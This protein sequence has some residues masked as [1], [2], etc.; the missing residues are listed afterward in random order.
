MGQ[1]PSTLG[2]RSNY[3]P[4]INLNIGF[5]AQADCLR[6]FNGKLDGLLMAEKWSFMHMR[7]IMAMP[8]SSFVPLS[9]KSELRPEMWK[10]V[11][12]IHVEILGIMYAI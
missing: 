6:Q 11:Q 9:S 2:M 4:K 8:S 7:L 12:Y 5:F 1:I 3:G 10:D